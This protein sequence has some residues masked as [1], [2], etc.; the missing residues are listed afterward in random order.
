MD[1]FNNN[2]DD[3][4]DDL[5][6]QG[7][8]APQTP[9]TYVWDGKQNGGRRGRRHNG[10]KKPFMFLVVSVICMALTMAICIPTILYAL[11]EGHIA[12]PSNPT[13]ESSKDSSDSDVSY[14]I[15]QTVS[16]T[17][18][19][20]LEENVLTQVYKKCEGSCASIY[21]ELGNTG[22]SIGSGFVLTEDGYIATNQHVVDGGTKVTVIFYDGEEY[23]AKI[24]GEDPIRDLAVLKIE[25]KGLTPL[26]IGNSDALSIGQTTIAIGTP[27]DLSLAGTMTMGIISGL[28]RKI[29]IENDSGVVTKTMHLIQTDTPINPGNSGGPLINM[30]GQVVGIN[31][32]KLID[33]FEGIGFAIPINSAVEI[34]N[35]LIQYGEVVQDPEADFVIENPRLGVQVYELQAG[36]EAFRIR[37]KCDYP[38]G[39]LVASVEPNTAVYAAG[40]ELYDIITEFDGKPVKNLN[41]LTNALAQYRAGDKV[42][43]TVFSFSRNFSQGEYKTLEF[44]LDSAGA[45]G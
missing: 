45:I 5:T 22:Y 32:L 16:V 28:D 24:V 41:D 19:P 15:S 44:V 43:M 14:E 30:A 8:P 1:E 21:V 34:F 6:P 36:L 11:D 27:Y 23:D 37:P 31:S 9:P 10:G 17:D 13:G 12:T 3:Q 38:E 7:E 25:A 26:P 29:P 40:L 33:E 4:N 20:F 2:R 39:V 18:T 35:Q 42:T